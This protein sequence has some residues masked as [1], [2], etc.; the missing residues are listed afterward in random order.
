MRRL[1][2]LCLAA[3]AGLAAAMLPIPS[4]L[5][6]ILAGCLVTSG[7]FVLLLCR[8]RT[9]ALILLP[10][11]FGLLWS[12][13][14]QTAILRP[15]QQLSGS[16]LE[17]T[18]EASSY[19]QF[20]AHGQWVK[21]TFPAGERRITADIFLAD[22]D[23]QV[24]PGDRITA[25]MQLQSSAAQGDYYSYSLG[26]FLN[27]YA[28]SGAVVQPGDH[29]PLRH[30]PAYIAHC[31][32]G[33]VLRCF[34]AD[35]QGYAMALT[36]GNRSSLSLTA[37][38]D[39]QRSGIYHALA[40]SGMH[41]AVLAGMLSFL[42]KPKYI[43]IFGIPLCICFA[44]ITG[45]SASVIRACVMEIFLLTGHALSRE[46]DWPTSLSLSALVLMAQNPWS[47]LNWGL[48]LSFL[49]VIGI[50]TLSG[51]IFK[52]FPTVSRKRSFRPLLHFLYLSLSVT[53]SASIFTFPLM[54]LYFGQ[55][56]L[57]APVT[58]LVTGTV[59]SWCFGGSLIAALLGLA[60][61]VPASLL[62]GIIAWGF[63]YVMA[64]ANKL[65][66]IPFS[67]LSTDSVYGIAAAVLVYVIL[68][69]LLF[70]KPGSRKIPLCCGIAGVTV[71]LTL[72]LLESTTP[73]F[74]ALDVGQ[75]QCLLF[76][77]SSG[78]VVVD[79]GGNTDNAGDLA[80]DH[81]LSRGI[82]RIRLLILTH[83]DEDHAGGVPELLKRIPVDAI[84]MP[85]LQADCRTDI[86]AAAFGSGAALY[87]ISD[88]TQAVL[89][90]SQFLIY[91]SPLQSGNNASLSIQAKLPGLSI[92]VTGDMDDSGEQALI[93]RHHPGHIDLL[94]AGHHGSKYSTSTALL[95][96]TTPCAAVISVGE[97]SYGHPAPETLERLRACGVP[98][99]RT[100]LQGTIW[101]KGESQWQIGKSLRKTAIKNS[102]RS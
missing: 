100:D 11:A 45:G 40:L 15:A 71:C 29:I 77:T 66:S 34:P 36:T 4:F 43:A 74:T 18:A 5:L 13:G 52:W 57:I 31:I 51:R 42:K 1:M 53:L 12:Y 82:R 14:F 76:E 70:G 67:C 41:M 64:A 47:I 19:G 92:L 75:G 38:S 50:C 6:L 9:A 69:L 95:R 59:I 24:C 35:V 16:E 94:V 73:A 101:I 89:G 23:R 56:S 48:Q 46:S 96:E 33:S 83:Y 22:T 2:Y 84:I 26:T 91:T 99:Y 58:N 44:V 10:M 21:A 54:A 32:E 78:P 30:L 86:E 85:D 25:S 88:D 8:R 61:P 98:V 28:H 7:I 72:L 49:S 97:N 20:T 102:N 79:C 87:A 55:I 3:C 90:S 62:A 68:L 93:Q 60:F 65:S 80:A 39:L 37:K 81:L 17:I 63:R 27:A